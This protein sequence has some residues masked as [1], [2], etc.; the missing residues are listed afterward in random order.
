MGPGL[1]L[2]SRCFSP[3]SEWMTG[4]KRVKVFWS[5]GALGL[6]L[7]LRVRVAVEADQVEEGGH[8][9]A[10]LYL[11]YISAASPLYLRYLGP[12]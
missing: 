2:D 7:G 3:R 8:C 6:E 9:G 4:S 5:W 12:G 1:R 10:H 11:P